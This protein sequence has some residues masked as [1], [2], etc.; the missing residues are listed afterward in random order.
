MYDNVERKMIKLENGPHYLVDFILLEDGK[1]KPGRY[2]AI[3][4]E[5]ETN[6]RY[7]WVELNGNDPVDAFVS[8]VKTIDE[9][10]REQRIKEIDKKHS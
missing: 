6:K 5:T 3:G 10:D 8:Y 1:D 2:M 4:H 9:I 7:G